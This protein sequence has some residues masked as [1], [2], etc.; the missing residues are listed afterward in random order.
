MGRPNAV[1][2]QFLMTC[3]L[4]AVQGAP[5]LRFMTHDVF[6]TGTTL[7]NTP[8]KHQQIPV[9]WEEGEK[10]AAKPAELLSAF[11]PRISLYPYLWLGM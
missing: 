1:D 5:P 7:S 6:A 10:M 3:H 11:S 8:D 4:H 9:F 2:Q